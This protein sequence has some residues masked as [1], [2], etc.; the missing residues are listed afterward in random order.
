[1]GIGT[2]YRGVSAKRP[3]GSH[4]ATRFVVVFFVP[5][6]PLSTDT[7]LLKAMRH[8]VGFNHQSV[9]TEYVLLSRGPVDP[10]AAARVYLFWLLLAPAVILGV[11]ALIVWA[12]LTAVPK[13]TPA[14]TLL[15]AAVVWYLTTFTVIVHRHQRRVGMR[16]LYR[17]GRESSG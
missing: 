2:D 17:A 9:V 5:V 13:G 7:Y 11:P 1:M 10:R 3:D 16:E 12:A 6:F 15:A 4:E 14:L 8:E